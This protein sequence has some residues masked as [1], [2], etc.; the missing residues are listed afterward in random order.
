MAK[1]YGSFLAHQSD[2]TFQR[3]YFPS[4]ITSNCKKN[5]HEEKLVL[6]LCLIILVSSE[7]PD[8]DL[9]L[10]GKVA[11]A[12]GRGNGSSNSEPGKRS[13]QFIEV[14]SQLLF[15]ENFLK[16]RSLT[17]SEIIDF[18]IFIKG[19]LQRY[20]AAVNRVDGNGMKFIKFHLPTHASRDMLR[21]GPPM[22]FD[23]STGE[24][25]HKEIKRPARQTQR[26]TKTFEQQTSVRLSDNLVLDRAFRQISEESGT[27]RSGVPYRRGARYFVTANGMFDNNASTPTVP[28]VAVWPN[29][30]LLERITSLICNSIIPH[31]QV[32]ACVY[33]FTQ[34]ARIQ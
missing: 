25:N 32:G 30:V 9:L 20:A 7:G 10:D 17:R 33:L 26:N 1:R 8:L 16:Q 14:I 15:I 22:S 27:A 4:G 12:T 2:R 21:Y 13:K 29:S 19:F 34:F 6:L 11:P 28:V 24:S 31:L 18:G 23:S 3:A 5:G